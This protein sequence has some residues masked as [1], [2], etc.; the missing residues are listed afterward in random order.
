M[1]SLSTRTA[2]PVA[3]LATMAGILLL[4]L[5]GALLYQAFSPLEYRGGFNAVKPDAAWPIAVI[6]SLLWPWGIPIAS[7]L[8]RRMARKGWVLLFVEI[9]WISI[10]CFLASITPE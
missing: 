3:G 8:A 1:S 7:N 2:F 10:V 5:P 6:V 4:G 9:V